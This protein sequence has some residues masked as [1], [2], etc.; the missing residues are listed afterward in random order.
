MKYSLM[1]LMVDDELRHEKTN[2]ILKAMLHMVGVSEMPEDADTAYHILNER[3]IPFKNGT[4]SFEDLVRFTKENGFDGLDMMS[5]QM[6][7]E[8]EEHKVILEKYGVTLSAVNIIIPFSDAKSPEAFEAMLSDAKNAIDQAIAAG[9]EKILLVPANYDRNKE[10]TREQTFQAMIKGMKSCL[11]YAGSKVQISTETLEASAIPW[12]SMGEMK[13]VFEMIPELKYTH[14]TGN[15]LVANED[16]L[17]FYHVF[18]DKVISVHF[19]DLGY[20]EGGDR[21]YRCMDGQV[22]ECVTL[23]EGEVDYPGHIRALL[24]NHYDGYITLEGGRPAADKWQEAVEAL[25]YFRGME[26]SVKKELSM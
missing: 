17:A 5:F 1:S 23:G 4:A 3:G 11:E 14:D 26:A 13:R 20:T 12:C 18:R 10:M 19:K 7:L 9:A 25:H 24:E 22:M 16:P 6:D 21:T 15:P 8:G 2:F